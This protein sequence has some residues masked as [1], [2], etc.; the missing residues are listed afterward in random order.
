MIQGINGF[1]PAILISISTLERRLDFKRIVQALIHFNQ[2]WPKVL[3]HDDKDP[4]EAEPRIVVGNSYLSHHPDYWSAIPATGEVFFYIRQA[5]EVG[6]RSV[7][8][9]QFVINFIL[10]AADSPSLEFIQSYPVTM[11]GLNAFIIRGPL[12]GDGGQRIKSLW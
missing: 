5:S 7:L 6:A 9:T 10:A 3:P 8:W 12:K 11:N 2:L 1:L 4:D